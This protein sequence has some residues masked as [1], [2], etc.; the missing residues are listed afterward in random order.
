MLK[1]EGRDAKDFGY[2]RPSEKLLN[3]LSKYYGLNRYVPQNNNF[4]VF[5]DYFINNIRSF[6]KQIELK[7]EIRIKDMSHINP[8][9]CRKDDINYTSKNLSNSNLRLYSHNQ[10]PKL[11]INKPNPDGH[12]TNSYISSQ[13]SST[14]NPP[15]AT[16][17]YNKTSF[18]PTS[19]CYGAFVQRK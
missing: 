2:D 17:D 4:V 16:F 5:D 12:L 3:F 14:T 11:D 18:M 8:Y 15:W 19:A 13:H 7:D 9:D 6:N 1:Y 10:V